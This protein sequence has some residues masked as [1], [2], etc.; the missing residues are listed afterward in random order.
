MPYLKFNYLIKELPLNL[1][2]HDI[3]ALIGFISGPRPSAFQEAEWG[4]L[5]NDIEENLTVQTVPSP[6]V[7]DAL[8]AIYRDE[9][10]IQMQRDYALQHIGG[11][12]IYLIH[13]QG[14]PTTAGPSSSSTQS[15]IS[16]LQSLL[17][18][19][20]KSAAT[21]ASKPWTGT[22]LNLL[23]GC[24]RAADYRTVEIPGLNADTL[25][26]LALPVARDPAAP[27]NARLPALQLAARRGSPAARDLARE[28]LSSPDPG[29]M[30]TQSASAVLARLGTPEDLPL[31]Q[32]ASSS[33][34]RHTSPALN[35]A[36][37]AIE[38][39]SKPH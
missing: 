28:I 29:V 25:V 36:I 24:L 15:Q 34:T 37:R 17:L 27:L 30:L 39:R 32:T 19:E 8:I 21:D 7:A 22:A 12:L 11:F 2:E 16:N 6:Q 9:T 4:S 18:S 13:T 1:A 23:D 3:Q 33:A 14:A 5:V 38:D 31:L 20:L 26:A 10:K 35:E